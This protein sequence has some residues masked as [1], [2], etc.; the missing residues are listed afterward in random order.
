MRGLVDPRGMRVDL[1]PEAER[2]IRAAIL[3]GASDEDIAAALRVSVKV[4][5]PVRQ[6]LEAVR[7]PR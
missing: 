3:A 1:P 6:A 4:V 5:R 2:R 7:R